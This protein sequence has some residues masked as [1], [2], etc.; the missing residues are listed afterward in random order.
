MG[1]GFLGFGRNL[2]EILPTSLTELPTQ[3]SDLR[4]NQKSLKIVF[5][6]P[7]QKVKTGFLDL[8]FGFQTLGAG[9]GEE[10]SRRIRI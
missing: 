2:V 5:I 4:S 6:C 7:Q 1:R 9:S 3:L 10:I 8:D